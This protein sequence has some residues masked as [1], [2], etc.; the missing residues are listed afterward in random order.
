[1]KGTGEEARRRQVDQLCRFAGALGTTVDVPTLVEDSLEP[2]LAM[3]EAQGA[4]IAL[5][6]AE[7]RLLEPVVAQGI[8]LHRRG[9]GLPASTVASL[10]TE[11]RAFP[12]QRALPEG[13]ASRLRG[14]AD[15]ELA[16]VPLWVHARLLGVVFLA[17]ERSPFDGTTLKLLTAAGR[18]L[19][20]AIENSL[21]LGD[22]QKSYGRLM[23]N[24]EELIRSERLAAMGQLSATM[25][26]EIRNPLATIFSAVSQI[27]KHSRLDPV[28]RQLLD[29][30]E[31]EALRM[32]RIVSGLLEFARPRKPHLEPARPR[33]VAVQAVQSFLESGNLPE[34]VEVAVEEGPADPVALCDQDLLG[35][36]IGLVI[37][38]GV[39]AVEEQGGVVRVGVEQDP[40]GV[41]GFAVTVSD[42]GCGIP[43]EHL[44]RVFEPFYSTRPS[45]IGL[46]L[47][48]VKRIAEDHGGSITIETAPGTGTTVRLFIPGRTAAEAVEERK[49]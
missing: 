15:R 24:Q 6:A 19:A 3:A 31:E 43:P 36:A 35:R 45:G 14:A 25:A 2:L 39:Q 22:L 44:S 41:R 29:I 8:S 9:K 17:R 12:S 30:T 7:P 5:A 33:A 49:P 40:G 21:L 37:A 1:L 48:T 47:P 23:D 28:A 42:N 20:L 13:L 27:R 10:G 32:N 38:N 16:V 11:A 4:L 34:G 46:S 26:H 18:Q